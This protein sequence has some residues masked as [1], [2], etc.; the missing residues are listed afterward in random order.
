VEAIDE[1]EA[2]GDQQRDAEQDVFESRTG[3]CDMEVV[4]QLRTHVDRR[5]KQDGGE[6]P[7]A[8]VAG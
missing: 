2:Q 8:Q 6:H 3:R 4:P 5:G 7:Q 1:F